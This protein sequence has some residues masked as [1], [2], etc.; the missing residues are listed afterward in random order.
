MATA[1]VAAAGLQAKSAT[2]DGSTLTL[3]YE[4]NLDEGVTLPSSA[5]TVTVG[6]NDRAVNGVSISG[7]TLNLTLASAVAAGETVKVGTPSRTVP[8]SSG[9]RWAERATPLA[10]TR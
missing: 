6:G 5:F 7:R 2:V 8:T 3:T 9:T 1:A 4:E 10:I